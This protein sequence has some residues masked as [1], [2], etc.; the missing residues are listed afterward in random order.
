MN[1]LRSLLTADRVLHA[2]GITDAVTAHLAADAEFEALYVSGAMVAATR[3]GLPD[4]GFVHGDD[5]ATVAGTAATRTGLPVI[6]D[7]DT[8]YGSVLQVAETVRRYRDAG[9]AG[10]HVEDQVAPKRCGHLAGKDVIDRT[11]ATARV[12]AAVTAAAGETVVIA[13]TDAWGVAGP[14]E[15]IDR[16]R[17]FT[18]AGA[19]LVFVEGPVTGDDLEQVASALPGVGLVVNRSE[20]GRIDRRLDDASLQALGVRLVIHPVSALLAAVAAVRDTYRRIAAT[21]FAEGIDGAAWDDLNDLLGLPGL[22]RDEQVALA[23]QDRQPDVS[24]PSTERR[25]A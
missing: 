18:D 6:A 21:G 15:A 23:S 19:D 16:A 25:P 1:S 8:G 14:G 3:I 11:E 13:R 4:L 24:K 22:L 9:I 10:L 17:M 5:I 20:A 2:P 12:R 7:A